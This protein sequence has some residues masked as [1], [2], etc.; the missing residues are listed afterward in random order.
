MVNG[1]G[2]HT[3]GGGELDSGLVYWEHNLVDEER[4]VLSEC[5]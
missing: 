5:I 2:T 4:R 1:C 3:V